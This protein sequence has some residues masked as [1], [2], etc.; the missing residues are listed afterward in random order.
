M[1]F[2]KHGNVHIYQGSLK[3][4]L[5]VC[6]YLPLLFFL[7]HTSCAL[8]KI[9]AAT[10]VLKNQFCGNK[11]LICSIRLFL[12]YK[13]FHSSW[14]YAINS[15][16]ISSQNSWIFKNQYLRASSIPTPQIHLL[17]LTRSL[18]GTTLLRSVPPAYKT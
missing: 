15:L 10:V 12:W 11:A 3:T 7:L 1:R 14:S 16:T 2:R 13:C 4:D 9:L 6:F 17:K 18:R 5:N 8:T